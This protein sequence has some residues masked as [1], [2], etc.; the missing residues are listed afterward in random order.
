MNTDLNQNRNQNEKS[1]VF[2]DILSKVVVWNKCFIKSNVM[3]CFNKYCYMCLI[4]Q[5]SILY[6][7]YYIRINPVTAYNETKSG[8]SCIVNSRTS[9]YFV[10]FCLFGVFRPTREFFFHWNGDVTII[11]EDLEIV[12]F[13]LH[14]WLLRCGVL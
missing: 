2:N 3:S 12:T 1:Q 9:F 14:S 5:Y 8:N 13:A 6:W 7:L 11:D 4:N 10:C